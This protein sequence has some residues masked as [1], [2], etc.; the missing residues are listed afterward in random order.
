MDSAFLTAVGP[1]LALT[2]GS[3]FLAFIS[4]FA[5]GHGTLGD[6]LLKD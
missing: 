6:F 3:F 4:E 1:I 5:S 2:G